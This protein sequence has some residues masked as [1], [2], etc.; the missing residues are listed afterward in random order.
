MS[1]YSVIEALEQEN[2]GLIKHI[3]GLEKIIDMQ[4]AKIEEGRNILNSYALRYG[5]VRDQNKRVK[6]IKSEAY[7]E[8]AERLKARC[9]DLDTCNINEPTVRILYYAEETID[10]VVKEMTEG[11]SGTV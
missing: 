8:F 4:N 1:N 11:N 6:E 7:K 9:T 3:E 2:L 5:T 10:D